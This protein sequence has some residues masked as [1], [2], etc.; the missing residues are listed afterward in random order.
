MIKKSV[1]AYASSL[2]SAPPMK[3]NRYL[4]GKIVQWC[5]SSVKDLANCRD[6]RGGDTNHVIPDKPQ[7]K[8]TTQD[9]NESYIKM[10][11]NGDNED[12]IKS[13]RNSKSQGE[14]GRVYCVIWQLSVIEG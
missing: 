7:K 3:T 6:I 10:I 14:Y 12:P 8:I 9:L 2:E 11:Y 13:S 1:T 4:G 5:A